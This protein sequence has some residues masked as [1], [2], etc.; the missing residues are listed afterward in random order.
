[1]DAFQLISPTLLQD[2]HRDTDIII[3]RHNLNMWADFNIVC[4]I[5]NRVQDCTFPIQHNLMTSL[6]CVRGLYNQRW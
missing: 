4:K 6:R 2:L 1:M 3:V 5:Q